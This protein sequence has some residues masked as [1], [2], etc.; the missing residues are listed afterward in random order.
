M[1]DFGVSYP[2]PRGVMT[3]AFRTLSI[4]P[5]DSIQS[6]LSLYGNFS[7]FV[8]DRLAVGISVQFVNQADA[9]GGD[10]G[11]SA[12]VGMI[13]RLKDRAAQG[14]AFG[15]RNNRLGITLTGLGKPA[16]LD[17]DTP[18]PGLG[19]RAGFATSII[20]NKVVQWNWEWDAGVYALPFTVWTSLG[21]KFSI[22]GRLN[23]S[24]GAIYGNN[25]LGG[26][27]IGL[28]GYT[29]GA[30][31][32]FQYED[33]PFELF[34]SYNPYTYGTATA[35]HFVGAEIAFG[36][37]DRTPPVIEFKLQGATGSAILF[38][39]NYDG[40]N[41]SVDFR[42][43]VRE[44]NLITN[45]MLTIVRKDGMVARTFRGTEERSV[46]LT[47]TTFFKKLFEKKQGLVIPYEL[48]WNGLTDTGHIASDGEYYAFVTACDEFGNVAVSASNK[49][50]L[51]LTPP[52][53]RLGVDTL[54]FSPNGDGRKDTVTFFNETTPGDSY[55]AEIRDG[56]GEV[57]RD[58]NWNTSVPASVVWDGNDNRGE[59]VPE[60]SYDYIVYGSDKAGNKSILSIP[61]IHLSRQ[62]QSVFL[63]V[64]RD[65]IS[66]NGD[67]VADK[68]SIVPQLSDTNGIAEWYISIHNEF[69]GPM[70]IK[71]GTNSV[72]GTL[73]WD[74]IDGLGRKVPDGVYTVLMQVEYDNG[75]KPVS[76]EYTVRVDTAVPE[77]E[78]G[79]K[80][81][82]FSPDNDGENDLLTLYWNLTDPSGIATWKIEIRDAQ[83]H[84]FKI[85]SGTG[86]PASNIIWDGRSD[87]GELVES[88]T[89]YPVFVSFAD[90]LGNKIV[91]MNA[92]TIPVDVLV[93]RIDR[94]LKIRINS[95]EFE[96]GEAVLKGM[97][98]PIL[99]RVAQIL[100]KYSTYKVEIQGHTDN[101]GSYEANQR[102]SEERA[103]AVLE[104][105]VRQG[106]A[107]SRLTAR[108]LG[109]DYPVA[110]NDTEEGR[111]GTAA[112][113][114]SSS[115]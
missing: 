54:I 74:G 34:Y 24:L 64:E 86:A 31:F 88:A 21:T 27:G 22:A 106:V 89:D 59:P 43:N 61:H 63:T 94:G 99:N 18:I 23:L 115:G 102:V 73:V 19:M 78:T 55:K 58:W 107:R 32:S 25:G 48:N 45:W 104:Y 56:D 69:G 80:P 81:E 70:L 10:M 38:S 13:L 42:L 75:N 28:I 16:L 97:S 1:G 91:S 39:P 108:G 100:K 15:L 36:V 113:N 52:V 17:S 29:A 4:E 7:K 30:S 68:T 112:W 37:L 83:G 90:T 12:D 40:A 9:S 41:D 44:A 2:F 46:R 5:P 67:N 96:F 93:E 105:L 110:S 49:I 51:D 103:K 26:S 33:T 53:I 62:A 77:L 101:V 8:N 20:T 3:V 6:A 85:F 76:P 47:F 82:L 60:G 111:R 65:A 87:G 79:F 95:I 50:T 72:P 57:V 98:Y 114:S 71:S 84:P 14:A 66:P 109:Y 92:M 11:I 35:S